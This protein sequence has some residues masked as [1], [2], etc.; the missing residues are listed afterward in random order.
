M[1]KDVLRN[2]FTAKW[3]KDDPVEQEKLDAVLQAAY[4]APVKNG[5]FDHELLVLTDSAEGK[6][7]KEYLYYDHTWCG[8]GIRNKPGFVGMKRYNG[9]VIAPVVLLWSA[10]I[11]PATI[12]PVNENEKIRIRDNCLLQA[13]FAMCAAEEQGL[14]TGINSTQF[15]LDVAQHLGIV[16]KE[17]ILSLGIG[18]ATIEQSK[19]FEKPVFQ[20]AAAM[21]T[22]PNDRPKAFANAYSLL[23][24]NRMFI[25][26]EAKR[27]VDYQRYLKN[28]A[29]F[30]PNGAPFEYIINRCSRD[31][32]FVVDAL[33]DGLQHNDN[34]GIITTV[35]EYWKAQTIQVRNNIEDDVHRFI[36]TLINQYILTN[37]AYPAR[38]SETIQFRDFD[39]PADA[40]SIAFA[41]SLYQTFLDGLS[42]QGVLPQVGFDIS[43]VDP[44]TKTIPTRKF[45][46]T[47][48]NMIKYI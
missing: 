44:A 47:F 18:Y 8:D 23:I 40:E 27:Y 33:A 9:Q 20:G 39:N 26:K 3:W 14:R 10:N 6:A 28:P 25:Q 31:I 30:D 35:S 37:V 29:F 22:H 46:P 41:D 43:N 7:I 2:R 5:K 15:G 32:G 19:R 4:L 34:S 11:P 12:S 17:C 38:Q 45:K 16:G 36:K 13:G 48:E 42:G 21:S 24:N 1:L